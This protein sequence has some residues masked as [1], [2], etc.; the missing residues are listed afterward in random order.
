[1]TSP[2]PSNSSQ[3]NS[4]TELQQQQQPP[5]P[6]M[7]CVRCAT[8][9]LS[10]ATASS[11]TLPCFHAFCRPCHDRLPSSGAGGAYVS[12]PACLSAAAGGG[13][14]GDRPP[15]G[16]CRGCSRSDSTVV[17]LVANCVTCDYPICASCERSHREMGYFSRHRVVALTPPPHPPPPATSSLAVGGPVRPGPGLDASAGAVSRCPVH[18]GEPLA[19]FC[20][21]CTAALCRRC[22]VVHD[23]SHRRTLLTGGVT[24]GTLDQ[25]TTSAVVSS[26]ADVGGLSYLE[27]VAETKAAQLRVAAKNVENALIFQQEQHQ[28]ARDAVTD[29]Y[30]VFLKALDDRR[31][32]TLRQLDVMFA[33]KQVPSLTQRAQLN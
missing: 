16:L 22:C 26:T 6:G 25:L 18:A 19:V 5:H 24:G 11:R 27:K 8:C 15:T 28:M 3:S 23:P 2:T 14:G 30:S 32:D 20:H 29:A 4:D 21:Q 9:G 13:G 17:E 31:A 10:V 1:M 7:G 12:C 33:E